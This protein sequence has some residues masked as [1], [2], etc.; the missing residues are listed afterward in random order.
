MPVGLVLLGLRL[1]PHLLLQLAVPT[2]LR[3]IDHVL[4]SRTLSAITSP[5]AVLES[6]RVTHWSVQL[7]IPFHPRAIKAMRHCAC[8]GLPAVVDNMSDGRFELDEAV[9]G[10]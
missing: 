3:A 8:N 5:A 10:A 9:L 1:S 6:V 2:P 7:A 4:C